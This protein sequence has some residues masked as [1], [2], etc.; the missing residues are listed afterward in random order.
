MKPIL[1]NTDMVKAILEG[2]KTITRR[3]IK[4]QPKT[5]STV[6][7]FSTFDYADIS[8]DGALK[9]SPYQ[10]GDILYV[11]ETWRCWRA[12][13]YEA[14][15]DIKYKAGGD[16]IRLYFSNGSTDN[17]NRDDYDSF[18]GKW[19]TG[20]YGWKPSIHMPKEAA[21]IF[22]RV[23][24]V[25]VARIQDITTKDIQKEGLTSMA[26]FAGDKE[27]ARQEWALL[28]D[29]TITGKDYNKYC[30]SSNPWVWV[31]EFERTEK[32]NE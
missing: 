13:R 6:T 9:L 17:P 12:H 27:I 4:P 5:D 7:L 26:V 1:F 14:T 22:L 24:N 8:Y 23:T 21:R 25:S 19:W 20:G 30:F 29:G 11:R 15:A 28:W 16:G 18:I 31:I 10:P 2:R 3:V 32:P